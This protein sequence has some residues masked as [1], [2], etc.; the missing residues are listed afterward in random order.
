MIPKITLH[1]SHYITKNMSFFS[2][3]LG[4][5]LAATPS[6]QSCLFL[7]QINITVRR[8]DFLLVEIM[9]NDEKDLMNENLTTNNAWSRTRKKKTI[10]S[11]FLPFIQYNIAIIY[12]I[13]TQ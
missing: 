11:S 1:F 5:L 8:T 3:G 13:K 7:D 6:R 4:S 2:N 10:N 9:R 12:R